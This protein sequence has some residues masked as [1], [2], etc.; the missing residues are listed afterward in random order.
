MPLTL[1]AGGILLLSLH[2]ETGEEIALSRKT[3]YAALLALGLLAALVV[4]TAGARPTATV[5]G[6]GSTF[7][8]PLY[9][10]WAQN[11]KAATITYNPI[12]SGGGIQA[13]TNKQVDFGASDAPLTKDQFA[14]CPCVQI[15][16]LMSATAVDYNIPGASPG[17][18]MTGPVLADIYLGKITYWDNARIKKINKGKTIPHVKV[19]PI[20]RSDG[21]GTTY[22]FTDYLSK[23]SREFKNK[24]GFATQ[25]QFPVGVGARGSN[26][27]S[28]TVKQT[29]GGVT[30]TDVAYAIK[31]HLKFFK[32]QNRAGKFTAPGIRAIQSAASLVKKVPSNNELHIVD[33][34]A[35]KKYLNAYPICTFSWAIVQKST[36]HAS[37][38]KA[39]LK[40]AVTKGQKV[41]GA[42][43]LLYIPIP[44]V[45]EKAALKT[46]SKI[47]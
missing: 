3:F 27:V 22:N 47:H 28:S 18:R 33:P 19:T 45:V 13:I 16:V 30:Y 12:G 4:G 21:S 31:N 7:A 26:G 1:G 8:A 2:G 25:V 35:S 46:L 34:P 36:D 32:V 6:A 5:T 41:P 29:Q 15:P 11:Y 39:F 23:V 37:E 43:K 42:L 14:S 40:W 10:L 38:I 20:F 44:K 24:V 9:A 17:L